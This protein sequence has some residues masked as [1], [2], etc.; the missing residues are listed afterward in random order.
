MRL[1]TNSSTTQHSNAIYTSRPLSA[2]ISTV[3][4]PKKRKVE[5]LSLKTDNG[6]GK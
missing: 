6:D 4:P 1:C 5:E 2:L 3:N